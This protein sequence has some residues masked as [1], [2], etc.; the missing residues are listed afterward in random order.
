MLML[1]MLPCLLAMSTHSSSWHACRQLAESTHRQEEHLEEHAITQDM[2]VEKE[3]EQ[4]QS[5]AHNTSDTKEAC[6]S[7]VHAG[8]PGHATAAV[9]ACS[10]GMQ[11]GDVVCTHGWRAHGLGA[12][13]SAPPP[14][15]PC[16]G[17]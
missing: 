10:T 6:A 9:C 16:L 13:L 5:S 4:E 3:E 14:L 7:P 8:T 15:P 1:A 17:T 11:V 12:C 2:Y